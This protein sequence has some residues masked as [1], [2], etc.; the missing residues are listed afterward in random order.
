VINISLNRKL[1]GTLILQLMIDIYFLVLF[2]T[3]KSY[4]G[5]VYSL[6]IIALIPIMTN[7]V[8]LKHEINNHHP[9]I[10]H[11]I[12]KVILFDLGLIILVTVVRFI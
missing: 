8:K 5:G 7:Y 1:K 10:N 6:F 11:H 12:N 2:L 4:N 3:D 9:E